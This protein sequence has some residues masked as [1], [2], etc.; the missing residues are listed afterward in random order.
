[1]PLPELNEYEVINPATR[2]Y[3]SKFLLNNVSFIRRTP[4]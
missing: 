2:R 3:G 1:M 4:S